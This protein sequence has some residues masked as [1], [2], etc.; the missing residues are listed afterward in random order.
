MYQVLDDKKTFLRRLL[1]LV[2]QIPSD[3]K[4]TSKYGK[5]KIPFTKNLPYPTIR[6][7]YRQNVV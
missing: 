5:N 6:K 3:Y 2:G 4:Y 7:G 1:S